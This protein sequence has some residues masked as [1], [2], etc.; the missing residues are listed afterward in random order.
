[1]IHGKVHGS[2]FYIWMSVLVISYLEHTLGMTGI[3]I[4]RGHIKLKSQFKQVFNL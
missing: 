4:F 2:L 1:M 3:I